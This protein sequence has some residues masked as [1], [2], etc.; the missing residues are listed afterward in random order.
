MKENIRFSIFQDPCRH[1]YKIEIDINMDGL[2]L[3]LRSAGVT[4]G[5]AFVQELNKK[6]QLI[7]NEIEDMIRAEARKMSLENYKKHFRKEQ[8]NEH[9]SCM[10]ME[11][12]KEEPEKGQGDLAT[13]YLPSGSEEKK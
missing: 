13:H 8:F 1:Q 2:E 10:Q 12:E 3:E 7:L 11:S 5:V 4:P 9:L 6:F